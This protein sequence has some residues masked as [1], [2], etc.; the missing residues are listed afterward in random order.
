[1]A[2]IE[3]AR[4]SLGWVMKG[5][6]RG[7]ARSMEPHTDECRSYLI[8]RILAAGRALLTVEYSHSHTERRAA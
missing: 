1:M 5:S 4:C 2:I 6:E 7:G 8:K 3:N